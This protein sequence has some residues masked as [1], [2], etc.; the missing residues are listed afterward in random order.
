MRRRTSRGGRDSDARGY[1]HGHHMTPAKQHHYGTSNTRSESFIDITA[2]E[3]AWSSMGFTPWNT[4][5][6]LHM[7]V[8]A[9]LD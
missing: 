4:E 2:W 1:Q 3:P 8:T 5:C 7:R 6:I 9:G